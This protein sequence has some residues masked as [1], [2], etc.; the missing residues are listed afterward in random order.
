[1]LRWIFSDFVSS[2]K[3]NDIVWIH[4]RPEYA[5][6]L[7]PM[8]DSL[9]VHTVLHMHNSFLCD[10]TP[11]EV[12]PIKDISHVFCSSFLAE[13]ARA[14]H[15]ETLK[16]SYVLY[17]GADGRL[18]YPRPARV[19]SN[20]SVP[21]ILFVGRLV[22]HKGVQILIKAM[23]ILA[24]KGV[25]VK[26]KVIGAANF[27]CNGVTPF[28]ETLRESLPSNVC[29]LGYKAGREL[30]KEFR[31]ADVFC[32]PSLWQEPLGMVNLEAM[33]SGIPVVASNVGG[34]PEV[35]RFGGGVLLEPGEPEVLAEALYDLVTNKD[36][37]LKLGAEAL[38]VFEN[39]FSWDV[40]R[41]NFTSIMK[42]IRSCS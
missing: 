31:D 37:R 16:R 36:K 32:C 25:Q 11:S 9:G 42:D 14:I 39:H 24:H 27:G 35:L 13:Q 28:I 30:A 33:A 8:L 7:R 17:N 10:L 21:V 5:G 6:A 23:T 18:F 3:K 40:I 15:P 1:M 29:L 20:S 4:N 41:T 22:P 38:Q 12:A 19:L 2:L 26:C 34:I